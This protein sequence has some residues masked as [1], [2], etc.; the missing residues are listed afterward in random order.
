MAFF[1]GVSIYPYNYPYEN[2]GLFAII[3][4]R[5]KQVIPADDSFPGWRG[6]LLF[7]E[8][9]RVSGPGERLFFWGAPNAI[10]GGA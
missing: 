6:N 5:L 1:L 10:L 4:H 7:L 3:W 2:M 9:A 8:R